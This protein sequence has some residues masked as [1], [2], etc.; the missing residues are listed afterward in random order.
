M[1][2]LRLPHVGRG[3]LIL[4]CSLDAAGC[5]QSVETIGKTS[6]DQLQD[7]M[8]VADHYRA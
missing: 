7:Q 6:I 1:N 4:L 3:A 2:N 5:D 8:A